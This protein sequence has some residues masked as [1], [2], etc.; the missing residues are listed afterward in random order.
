MNLSDIIGKIL[1]DKDL[2]LKDFALECGIPPDTLKKAIKRGKLSADI[3]RKIQDKYGVRKEYLKTG[4][5]DTYVE[6]GTSRIKSEQPAI[7]DD[8]VVK[9]YLDGYVGQIDLYKK[10]LKIAEDEIA[11]LKGLL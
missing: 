3:V 10:L 5:G 11:R 8:P 2:E 4:K 1:K 9:K 6:N 7:F